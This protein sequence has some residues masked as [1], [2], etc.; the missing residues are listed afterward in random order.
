MAHDVFGRPKHAE[1][2]DRSL[3]AADRR[4]AGCAHPILFA[5]VEV[6]STPT[7]TRDPL[8]Y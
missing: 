8:S 7:A 2:W 3:N 6:N 1:H 5:A 4:P